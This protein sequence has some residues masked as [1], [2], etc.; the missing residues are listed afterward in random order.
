MTVF[1]VARDVSTVITYFLNLCLYFLW[2]VRFQSY[3]IIYAIIIYI[4]NE[5]NVNCFNYTQRIGVH[6]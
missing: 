5:N 2:H 6:F 3:E 1:L 4:T